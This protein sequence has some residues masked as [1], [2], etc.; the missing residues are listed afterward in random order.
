M[1]GFLHVIARKDDF[2]LITDIEE[3][4]TYR[5]NTDTARHLFCPGCGVKSFYMP[6]SHPDGFSVNLRCLENVNYDDISIQPFDGE[7]WETAIHALPKNN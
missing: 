1:S 7:N 6:R 2:R 5:F 4:T 3:L